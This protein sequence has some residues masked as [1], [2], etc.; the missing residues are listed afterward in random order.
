MKRTLLVSVAAIALAIGVGGGVAMVL[1]GYLA[2]STTAR[3][4][5]PVTS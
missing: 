2:R 4:G 3:P 1:A 5:V